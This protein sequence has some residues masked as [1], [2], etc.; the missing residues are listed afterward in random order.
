MNS[1]LCALCAAG[2]EAFWLDNGT[3]PAGPRLLIG[4]GAS[5]SSFIPSVPCRRCS[6]NAPF[7]KLEMLADVNVSTAL[8]AGR[9]EPAELVALAPDVILAMSA[10][11]LSRG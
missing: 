5:I 2:V 9:H 3:D 11:A 7:A 1:R 8:R 10:P 6:P 4:V